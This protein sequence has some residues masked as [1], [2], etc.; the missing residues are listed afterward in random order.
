MGRDKTLFLPFF[1]EETLIKS[2]K[3][4]YGPLD[5]A[6]RASYYQFEK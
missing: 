5:L 3:I 1:K 2:G 4:K 6:H